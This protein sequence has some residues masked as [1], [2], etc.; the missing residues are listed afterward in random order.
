MLRPSTGAGVM[1]KTRRTFYLISALVL[2]GVATGWRTF[3]GAVA[4]A[5]SCSFSVSPTRVDTQAPGRSGTITID[6]QEGC[7]WTATPVESGAFGSTST[8]AWLQLSSGGG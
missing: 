4:R 6:T 2:G 1:T 5:Q 3:D 7:A 8:P